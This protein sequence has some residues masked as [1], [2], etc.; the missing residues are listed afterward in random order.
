MSEEEKTRSAGADICFHEPLTNDSSAPAD[1]ARQRESHE[2]SRVKGKTSGCGRDICF[3]QVKQRR[4]TM[5]EEMNKQSG[6]K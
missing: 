2:Y 5:S 1:R 4:R 3:R 6:K